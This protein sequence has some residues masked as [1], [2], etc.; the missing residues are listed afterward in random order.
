MD[1]LQTI[2]RS[3]K[4]HWTSEEICKC[5]FCNTTSTTMLHR[6]EIEKMT[7][8]EVGPTAKIIILE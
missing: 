3:I 4:N 6:F 1:R 2:P 8:I 5:Y 7:F